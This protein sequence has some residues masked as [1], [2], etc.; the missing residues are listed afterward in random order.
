MQK[1]TTKVGLVLLLLLN[2]CATQA[3]LQNE[4]IFT[5]QF[6]SEIPPSFQ[7]TMVNAV[8]YETV[9]DGNVTCTSRNTG[10]PGYYNNSI[11]TKCSQGTKQVAIPYTKMATVDVNA[12][13]RNAA[14]ESCAV[15]RCYRAFGNSECINKPARPS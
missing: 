6:M 7:E 2:A 11:E 1:E 5:N 10:F 4:A 13:R 3:Y 15:S 8:R 14:I 9:P 12:P